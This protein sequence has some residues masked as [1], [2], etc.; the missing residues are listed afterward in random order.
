V[1]VILL[2]APLQDS[3]AAQSASDSPNLTRAQ[4]I[5]TA[6]RLAEHRWV[7][8]RANRY[9]TCPQIT[10]YVSDFAVNDTII[11]LPYDW[12][13]MDGPEA[14][15]GRLALGLAAGSHAR[16]GSSSCTAGVDCSGFISIAWGSK[17]KYGTATIAEIGVVPRY[18]W[19][20]DMEP[21]DALV[22]PGDHIVLFAG[23]NQD[24]RPIVYEASG[25]YHRVVRRV[26]DWA[27]L[28]GYYPL[29]YRFLVNP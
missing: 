6:A 24:G 26:W 15:D 17:R 11:G 25:T 3:L 16:H 29:Q 13:G 8:R 21:G 1:L 2:A 9:A 22:K 12:G 5:A 10:A 4:I 19:F 28:T 27:R 14:F 18:N 20:Q 23:Y 7:M